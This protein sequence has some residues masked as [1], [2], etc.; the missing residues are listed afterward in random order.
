MAEAIK[1]KSTAK[2]STSA[3][4]TSKGNNKDSQK[5]GKYVF[6]AGVILAVVIALWPEPQEWSIWLLIVL[7]L[8]GG[9][10]RISKKS[11]IHFIVMAVG[12]KTFTEI[13]GVFPTLGEFMGN[14]FSALSFFMGAAVLSIVFRNV[15][16]WF[17]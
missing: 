1:K 8:L 2:K 13:I 9:Y 14:I 6:W 7:G 5:F 4:S 11:E 16:G 15:I 3:K 17:K 12:L 10:M